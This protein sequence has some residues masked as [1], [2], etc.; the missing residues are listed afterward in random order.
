MIKWGGGKQGKK[1]E[2][3]SCSIFCIEHYL[4]NRL[5][6][7]NSKNV[8]HNPGLHGKTFFKRLL[9]YLN[10]QVPASNFIFTSAIP[11]N[12]AYKA[13]IKPFIIIYTITRFLQVTHFT[14]TRSTYSK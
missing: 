3:G 5:K 4:S 14:A 11:G 8:S 1:K 9:F 12:F 6:L 13:D 10:N 7:M 2:G